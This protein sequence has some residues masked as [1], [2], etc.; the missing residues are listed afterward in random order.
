[1]TQEELYQKET[2]REPKYW[3]DNDTYY[4]DDFIY[5]LKRKADLADA[6]KVRR[7]AAEFLISLLIERATYDEYRDYYK[8]WQDSITAYDKAVGGK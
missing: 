2:G 5:W 4:T 7:E 8:A 6:E 1:M 3:F